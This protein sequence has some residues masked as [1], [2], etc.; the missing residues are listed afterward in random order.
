VRRM[1][2][3]PVT[4]NFPLVGSYSSALFNVARADSDQYP[5][6]V[7]QGGRV[8]VAPVVQAASG[9]ERPGRR[10]IQFSTG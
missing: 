8:E 7:Q 1:F 9:S 3:L 2:K 6:I 4:L 10:V 5:R